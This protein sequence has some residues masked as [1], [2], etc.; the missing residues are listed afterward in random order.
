MY[1]PTATAHVTTHPAGRA[2][3]RLHLF[4]Q[5][6]T[7]NAR[8]IKRAIKQA[9]RRGVEVVLYLDLGETGSTMWKSVAMG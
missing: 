2:L 3:T 4:S 8:P 1:V 6:P 9:C 7:L 5:T